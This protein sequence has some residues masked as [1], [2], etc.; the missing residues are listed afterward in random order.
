MASLGMN[1]NDR[2]PITDTRMSS[3]VSTGTRAVSIS[4]LASADEAPDIIGQISHIIKSRFRA[5]VITSYSIR[6]DNSET[7]T[8]PS[9]SRDEVRSLC[10]FSFKEA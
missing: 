2:S 10:L 1:A 6:T 4:F 3:E 5:G 9:D 7:Q 8:A